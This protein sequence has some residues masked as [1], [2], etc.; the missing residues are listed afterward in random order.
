MAMPRT[1]KGR[2]RTTR[3]S[4]TSTESTVQ[5]RARARGAK[6]RAA[7]DDRCVAYERAGENDFEDEDED[8]DKN[9]EEEE[10][11]KTEVKSLSTH[12]QVR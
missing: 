9:D 5:L 7:E 2:E 8:E 6:E 1:R 3:G 12:L 4:D 11:D 10:E